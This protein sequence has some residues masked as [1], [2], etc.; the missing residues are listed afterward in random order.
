LSNVFIELKKDPGVPNLWPSKQELLEQL[1]K[2]RED[3]KTEKERKKLEKKARKVAR[4][5]D[6]DDN[7]MVTEENQSSISQMAKLQF[8]AHQ[9]NSEFENKRELMGDEADDGARDIKQG[10]LSKNSKRLYYREFKKVVEAADVILEVLDSRDPLGCRCVDIEKSILSQYQNKKIVLLMNKID[11]IPRE[12]A[13]KWMDYLR[14]EYPVVAFK[15]STQK[16]KAHKGI[17]PGD[18]SKANREMLHSGLC[19]GAQTLL[20]LLKNYSRSADIKK[21]ITVGIIGYPN[22]GKSSVINSLK[23]TKVASVGS[24]PGVTRVVQEIHLDND[25][26]LLDCPGIVFSSSNNLDSDVILRNAIRVDELEDVV[27]PVEQ[28]LKR[29]KPERLMALYNIPPFGDAEDFLTKVAKAR[30]MLKKGATPK[31]T[32]AGR[33]VLRDWNTGKIQYFT[34]PPARDQSI[35]AQ[36]KQ[37]KA[38]PIWA[39]V[40]SSADLQQVPTIKEHMDAK[41]EFVPMVSSALAAG[42]IDVES[43]DDD[44]DVDYE[45]DEDDEDDAVDLGSDD[46][47]EDDD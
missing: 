6:D 8:E 19:I 29:C 2:Q 18:A 7:E 40:D 36:V 20:Q 43:D 33:V 9:K 32:A 42:T 25:I 22:V 13:Q 28:L 39:N 37:D 41:T 4:M 1:K 46:D 15:S 12:V 3:I 21:T 47:D 34:L 38:L 14:E 17:I 30:G 26:K 10:A 24:T 44:E 23:R 35:D 5:E 11:L 16:Q 27:S 45:L 31:I